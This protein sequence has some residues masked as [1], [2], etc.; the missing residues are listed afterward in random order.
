MTTDALCQLTISEMSAQIATR[1]LS[2]IALCDAHLARIAA[3]N[4]TLHAFITVTADLAREQAARHDA[5]IAKQGP[6]GPLH[7][8]PIALKDIYDTAGILTSG[9]SAH[10]QSR[11]PKTDSICWERLER[12]GAVLLGKLATHEFATGGPSYDLPWPPARNPWR[13][14]RFPGGSSSGAGASV[15]ARMAAGALGSDTGGS[16]RLPAAYCGLVG[17]KPTYGRVPKEGVLPLSWTFDNCGP[18]TRTVEDAAIML[19]AIAGHDAR[20]PT[21]DRRA[22]PDFRAELAS[23]VAGL[24]IGIAPAWYDPHVI[25]PVADAMQA[26]CAVF[27]DLGATVVDVTLPPLSAFESCYRAIVLAE[28]FAIYER[29]VNESGPQF[30]AAFRQRVLPGA[31]VSAADYVAGLQMQRALRDQVLALFARVDVLLMPTIPSAAP[32]QHTLRQRMRAG[33]GLL[34]SPFNIAQCP[35]MSVC[36]GFTERALPLGMQLIAPPFEESR[37]LQVGAAYEG[38]TRWHERVPQLVPGESIEPPD[39]RPPKGAALSTS[40]EARR[41]WHRLDT[42]P[43]SVAHLATGVEEAL[44]VVR[45]VRTPRHYGEEPGPTFSLVGE[46]D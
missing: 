14:D 40:L 37:V 26:A 34:T 30:G 29:G 5:E 18:L 38:A 12:A 15:S 3:L 28:A 1:D 17:L 39:E 36:C 4:D 22:V 46:N 33:A 21:T 13:L 45:G 44:S 10:M 31:L 43:Q 19:Q 2:P 23:G 25:P 20:D 7:G 24:T 35:A 11:I 32:V 16:I 6:R 27:R 41:E 9:H 8:I 42:E